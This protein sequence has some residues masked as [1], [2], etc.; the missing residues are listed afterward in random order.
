MG[1][2]RRAAA[3]PDRGRG[4][5]RP[6]GH[7]RRGGPRS[8]GPPRAARMPHRGAGR[9]GRGGAREL[10]LSARGSSST[11]R[12][13]S[14]PSRGSTSTGVDLVVLAVPCAGLPAALGE[15]GTRMHDR[16]AVLVASKGLVPPLGT[17]PTAYVSERVHARAVAAL[18][19]PAHAREAV[20]GSASVVVATRDPDLRRQLRDVLE[21]GGL[22]ADATD[23]VTGTE[24]AACAKDAAALASAAAAPRRSEPGRRRRR[25]RLLGGARACPRERRPQR[26]V[27]R[28]RRGGR[29]RGHDGR[30][31]RDEPPRR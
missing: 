10:R 14:G 27:R 5:R 1:V 25:A 19:G 13:T 6:H 28:P 20:E 9:A 18:A 15:V 21:A 16:S 23:D 4:G 24:L 8:G 30:G 17:T 11:R 7:R 26:D 2:A 12:S 3:A 29:P 31:P 22:N